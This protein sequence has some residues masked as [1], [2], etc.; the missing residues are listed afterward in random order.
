MTDGDLIDSIHR[1]NPWSRGWDDRSDG[2]GRMGVWSVS[3]KWNFVKGN[4]P[5]GLS[6]NYNCI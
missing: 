2:A 6:T 1:F 4:D 5:T 3:G